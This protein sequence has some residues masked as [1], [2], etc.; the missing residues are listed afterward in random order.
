[1][2]PSFA[3]SGSTL[4]TISALIGAMSGAITFL[5]HKLLDTKDSEIRELRTENESLRN[6]L[7]NQSE[8]LRVER[9]RFRDLAFQLVQPQRE[10][11]ERTRP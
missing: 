8:Q 1:M 3:L 10:A 7:Q 2:E 4:A 9:D 11:G 6:Q 5:A